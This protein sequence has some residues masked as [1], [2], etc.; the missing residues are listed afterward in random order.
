MQSAFVSVP[1]RDPSLQTSSLIMTG[2]LSLFKPL[3]CINRQANGWLT[4]SSPYEWTKTSVAKNLPISGHQVRQQCFVLTS[5][6]A[7][8]FP[9]SYA[10]SMSVNSGATRRTPEIFLCPPCQI[11]RSIVVPVGK[12]AAIQTNEDPISKHQVLVHP[13]TTRARL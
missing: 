9:R 3:V 13:S 8:S 4:F 7:A 6:R 2:Q 1:T 10:L 12:I 11:F 5:T